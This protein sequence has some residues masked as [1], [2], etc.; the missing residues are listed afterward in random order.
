M[1]V[2]RR[3]ESLSPVQALALLNNGFLLTQSAALASRVASERDGLG[4]QVRHAFRLSI[5]RKPESEECNTLIE[6]A[7]DHGLAQ[8]CRLIL[9]LNEF[10][11]VD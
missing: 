7:R 4:E 8:T 3:T 6:Y 10:T 1:R 2:D 5:S 11:F 9:N